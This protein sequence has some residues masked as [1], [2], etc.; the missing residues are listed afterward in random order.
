MEG[1]GY[2]NFLLYIYIWQSLTAL[3]NTIQRGRCRYSYICLTFFVFVESMNPTNSTK[4][5]LICCLPLGCLFGIIVVQTFYFIF[6]VAPFAGVTLK[7]TGAGAVRQ[8]N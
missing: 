1:V 8:G 7:M 2:N 3:Q 5:C 6:F 4:R